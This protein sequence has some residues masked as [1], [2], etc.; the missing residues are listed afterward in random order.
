MDL[1][2]HLFDHCSVKIQILS[3]LKSDFTAHYF[4]CFNIS[5]K[6]HINAIYLGLLRMNACW[7]SAQIYRDNMRWIR[8]MHIEKA[9]QK[10]GKK[11]T[12]KTPL[13]EG[14]SRIHK[15]KISIRFNLACKVSVF[16]DVNLDK[17]IFGQMGLHF[18][19]HFRSQFVGHF[20]KE[21]GLPQR[22]EIDRKLFYKHD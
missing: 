21:I 5:F 16:S 19:K 20:H 3:R 1:Y 22:G 15:T 8:T 17:F 13:T 14:L 2:I 6:L 11:E 18:Q 4:W 12:P 7:L 10:Y 9:Y